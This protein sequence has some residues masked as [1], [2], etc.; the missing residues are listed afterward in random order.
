MNTSLLLSIYANN[1][2]EELNRC[3]DSIQNQNIIL[4]EIILIIDGP[5]DKEIDTAIRKWCVSIS[6]KKFPLH[7]NMGLAYALNYGLKLCT[8]DWVFRMDID[9]VCLEDRFAKQIQIINENPNIDILGGNIKCFETYPYFLPGRKVPMSMPQIH[10]YIKYR[11][12]VNHPTVFFNKNKILELGGYPDARLGQDYLLWIK[13]LNNGLKIQNTEEILV[14]MKVDKKSYSRRGL[15][16]LKY[17]SMPYLMMYKYKM[18]NI[19]ELSIGLF[20]RFIYC[21]YSSIMSLVKL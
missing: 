4:N 13:A 17:D 8:N 7:K 16:N 20:I 15:K 9:D 5:V 11:N 21:T 19:M 3:F 2:V 12:P 6:I 10:R 18:T 1:T 14:S